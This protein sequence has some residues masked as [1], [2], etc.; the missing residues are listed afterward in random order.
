MFDFALSIAVVHHLSTRARRIRAIAA[1]LHTLRAGPD[2]GGSEEGGSEGG[3]GKG[4]EAFIY[5]W[6]LEQKHSR[7]GWDASDA[8]DVLVPWVMKRNGNGN[9]NGGTYHRFYHLYRQG[10]LEE[11]VRQAGGLVHAAGFERDNWWAVVR[12]PA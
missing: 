7:R 6:A 11:D 1:L 2:R 4:G 5:V 3:G 12:R 10:E 8:Q 9:G